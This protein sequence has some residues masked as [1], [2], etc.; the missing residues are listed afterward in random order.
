MLNKNHAKGCMLGGRDFSQ[1]TGFYFINSFCCFNTFFCARDTSGV[2]GAPTIGATNQGNL[3]STA[4]LGETELT[5]NSSFIAK[6][7]RKI[8]DEERNNERFREIIKAF[9]ISLGK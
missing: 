5:A 8:V 1:K 3:E 7:S 2:W 4:D 9:G 6:S